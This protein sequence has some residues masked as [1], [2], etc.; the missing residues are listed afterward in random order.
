MVVG[1]PDYDPLLVDLAA[2]PG[3]EILKQRYAR[4]RDQ[5]FVN[6]AHKIGRSDDPLGD[7]QRDVD[8][9]RGFWLGG[10][11]FIRQVEQEFR[12]FRQ[13]QEED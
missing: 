2:H 8:Y 13:Q 11:W 3:W 7:M 6:L 12:A 5:Y 10:R 9:K 4:Q 1:L